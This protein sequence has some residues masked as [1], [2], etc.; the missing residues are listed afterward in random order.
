MSNLL[1]FHGTLCRMP[2]AVLQKSLKNPCWKTMSVS[3]A[4]VITATTHS[5]DVERL[6]SAYNRMKTPDRSRL[7]SDGLNDYLR[8]CNRWNCFVDALPD[9]FSGELIRS[10]ENWFASMVKLIRGQRNW[11]TISGNWFVNR[12]NWFV[13]SRNWFHSSGNWFVGGEIDP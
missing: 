2:F 10:R 3:L 4:G 5:C 1:P 6:I 7:S 13:S 11:L 12:K 9:T 8:I